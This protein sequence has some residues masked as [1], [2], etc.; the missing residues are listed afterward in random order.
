MYALA[1][2]RHEHLLKQTLEKTLNGE[3]RTQNAP[4][5][6]AK[7]LLNP[8]GREVGWTFIKEN[9]AQ[10][11]KTFPEASLTRMIEGVTGLVEKKYLDDVTAFLQANEMKQGKKTVAQHKEKLQVAVAFKEREKTTLAKLS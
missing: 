6:V 8:S 7:V 9:W 10:I 11:L 4:Y 5:L 1:M 2:F 3:V